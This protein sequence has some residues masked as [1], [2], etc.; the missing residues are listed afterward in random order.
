M[1]S[2]NRDAELALQQIFGTPTLDSDERK[3]ILRRDPTQIGSTR[4]V[5]RRFAWIGYATAA[6][7]LALIVVPRM[8]SSTTLISG[9]DA[10]ERALAPP[11]VGFGR[12]LSISVESNIGATQ[13][14]PATW[15]TD[16]WQRTLEN[17]TQELAIQSNRVDG[18]MLARF[19]TSGDQWEIAR[20]GMV[21]QG[22]GT[23]LSVPLAVSTGFVSPEYLQAQLA[24][25]NPATVRTEQRGDSMIIM[26]AVPAESSQN[27]IRDLGFSI[28]EM[29]IEASVATAGDQLE[30]WRAS[31]VDVNGDVHLLWQLTFT[32]WDDQLPGQAMNDD[33]FMM[34]GNSSPTP[35]VDGP[36]LPREVAVASGVFQRTS[37]LHERADQWRVI[38]SGPGNGVIQ[39][40][41][42]PSRNSPSDLPDVRAHDTEIAGVTVWWQ[43]DPEGEWPR[44]AIWDDGRFQFSL[45]VLRQSPSWS[46][47]ELLEVVQATGQTR[48]P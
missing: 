17:G 32:V 9:T 12:H 11:A 26:L 25:S 3:R 14:L 21:D 23:P 28:R 6:L 18:S 30:W 38:Y 36:I 1:R 2:D 31:A 20:G 16:V 41:I 33:L 24:N 37:Q 35:V 40:D 13:D 34:G 48:Q 42:T 39:I 47:T 43:E 15:Q 10:A 27:D 22:I 19:V 44:I 45:S 29:R 8:D 46:E 4:I 7:V 5:R